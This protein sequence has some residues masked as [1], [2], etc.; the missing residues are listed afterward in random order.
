MN[1]KT[2]IVGAA[3]AGCLT[4]TG[5]ANAASIGVNFGSDYTGGGGVLNLA[6]T[7]SAGVVAQQNWNNAAGANSGAALNLIDDSGAATTASVVWSSNNLW[8]GGAAAT[9]DE[10][11]M[12]GWLDDGVA[13]ASVT[14]SN[15]PYALYDVYVYFSADNGNAGNGGHAVIDGASFNSVGVFTNL[16]AGNGT[17]FNGHVDGSTGA[18]DPSYHLAAGLNNATLTVTSTRPA[19]FRG[20]IAGVQIVDVIPEPASVAL[21]GL[22]G[23][24]MLR[25]R[26]A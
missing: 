5:F 22:G 12:A 25:R 3:A 1:L 16:N 11:L 8:G 6:P 18:V 14:V 7:D 9:A 10:K 15:I 2:W 13:G 20:A 24:L 17:F 4:L 19:G 21:L 26:R 23:L